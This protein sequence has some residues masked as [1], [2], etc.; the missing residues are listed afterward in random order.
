MASLPG[1]QIEDESGQNQ[2]SPLSIKPRG[3]AE[4]YHPPYSMYGRRRAHGMVGG[5]QCPAKRFSTIRKAPAFF[6]KS[7]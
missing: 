2:A 6:P 3:V 1:G 7:I 4:I 5:K